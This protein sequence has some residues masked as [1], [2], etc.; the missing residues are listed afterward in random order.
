MVRSE[1]FTM[2]DTETLRKILHELVKD[3]HCKDVCDPY[4]TLIELILANGTNTKLLVQMKCVEKYRWEINKTIDHPL[5]WNEAFI[6]WTEDGSAKKFSQ[7]YNEELTVTE[8]YKLVRPP[9][10]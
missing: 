6:R 4:C 2:P 9:K 10:E 7:V 5:T 1:D 8:I 3:C